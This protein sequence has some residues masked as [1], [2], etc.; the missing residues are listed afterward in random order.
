MLEASHRRHGK[1]RWERLLAPAIRL[2]ENGFAVS[3]RLHSLLRD[4]PLLRRDPAARALYYNADGQP[5]AIGSLLR[6]PELAAVL[7]RLGGRGQ[8]CRCIAGCLRRH[9]RGGW[10]AWWRLSLDDLR[11][12]RPRQREAVCG[13]YRRWRICGMPPPSSG[14]I[15]V[16]ADTRP[17]R[18][19]RLSSG[20][21][22]A[23]RRPFM[24]F[25]KPGVLPSPTVPDSLRSRIRQGTDKTA[26]GPSLSGSPCLADES[27]QGDGCKAQPGELASVNEAG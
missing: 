8:P 21:S 4:D 1:L 9:R 7:R 14:G 17:G 11:D 24:I 19:Q 5:L 2:A 13:A 26:T 3:P 18:A 22:W 6:N 25:L 27:W 10:Q 15:A 12:Y 20:A 16:S 23:S